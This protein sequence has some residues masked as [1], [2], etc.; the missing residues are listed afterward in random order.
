MTEKNRR[1]AGFT[2]IELLVVV[3]I[4]GILA[5]VAVPSYLKSVETTKADDAVSLVNMIGTTNKMYALD[6][7]NSYIVGTFPTAANTGCGTGA[8]PA[9]G[10]GGGTACE[11]VWCKYL[12]DQNFGSKPYNFYA[13]S[14][15]GGACFASGGTNATAGAKR[16]SGTYA[17]WGYS[18]SSQGVITN[19]GGAPTPTY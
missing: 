5:S 8:C 3:L 10:P 1:R 14:P 18:M 11:L 15:T 9:T 17:A 13:C 19:N 4:I 6:H 7:S 2:L 12:A 16:K